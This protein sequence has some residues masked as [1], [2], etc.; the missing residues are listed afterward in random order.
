MHCCPGTKWVYTGIPPVYTGIHSLIPRLLHALGTRLGVHRYTQVYTCRYT[1]V[2]QST[3]AMVAE[4]N[5]K[6]YCSSWI[7]YSTEISQTLLCMYIFRLPPI[8]ST[9]TFV[10]F[11]LH[12]LLCHFVYSHFE[13]LKSNCTIL[14]KLQQCNHDCL[15]C[16]TIILFKTHPLRQ[17]T[18][19]LI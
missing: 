13:S 6:A 4:S 15:K 19:I 5:V 1:W 2:Y 17:T 12:T 16:N 14:I 9:H 7:L 10:P 3:C 18:D 11:R 8:S